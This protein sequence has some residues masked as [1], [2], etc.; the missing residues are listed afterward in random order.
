MDVEKDVTE[1]VR[2]IPS[3]SVRPKR[4]HMLSTTVIAKNIHCPSCIRH[5][6]DM[7][8]TCSFHDDVLCTSV[9]VVSGEIHVLHGA[10]VSLSDICQE[11]TNAAFEVD[12]AITVDVDDNVLAQLD[13]TAVSVDSDWE[14]ASAQ[15]K[16]PSLIRS[17]SGW[18]CGLSSPM[19]S[20]R[21]RHIE[22]CAACQENAA[23][24]KEVEDVASSRTLS[25]KTEKHHAD[26]SAESTPSTIRTMKPPHARSLSTDGSYPHATVDVERGDTRSGSQLYKWQISVGGMT[27]SSCSNTIKDSLQEL[28]YVKSVDVDLM[29]NSAVIVFNGGE[30][31]PDKLQAAIEELG[32]EVSGAELER[33]DSGLGA[34]STTPKRQGKSSA[35]IA[36]LSIGGMTC[37]SCTTAV[38]NALKDMPIVT[39]VNVSLMTNSA[40]VQLQAGKDLPDIVKA[41]EDLGYE[42]A[43]ESVTPT[44]EDDE[45]DDSEARARERSIQ[46][47]IDGMYCEHCPP[48]ILQALEGHQYLNVTKA[49][50][51]KDSLMRITYTPQ[52]PSFTVR[53]IVTTIKSLDPR[54]VPRIYH[55]PSLEE[56]SQQMQRHERKKILRRLVLSTILTI[57]TLLIGVIWMN[58]TSNA[59]SDFW[60]VNQKGVS[61]AEWALFA[62]ATPVYFCAAD[63]F[64]VRAIKEIRSLWRRGSKVPIHRRFIR[65]G[66]M[67]LLISAGTTVSYVS[68]LALLIVAAS[69]P[70]P[71]GSGAST[72]SY[73]DTVVFLTFFIL[74][75]RYLEAYSKSRAG[76]A[77]SML[78]QLRPREAIIQ[79]LPSAIS[80]GL[81]DK[82]VLD[83]DLVDIGDTIFV[84]HGS[85]PAADGV[86][87]SQSG[88]FDESSLTGESRLVN[89]T[90]G[91]KIFI[92]T[93]NAGT[94][95]AMKVTEVG[96]NSMLDQ[97]IAVVREGQTKRAPVERVAD[98]LTGYFVPV[99]T[100]LAI[101]T[102]VIWFALGQ[103]GALS[104]AYLHG[105]TGGWAFWSLQFAI[106][107]F[108]VACPCG[109]GLAAPTA[110]FVGSGLAAKHG[111]LAR[112]GGQAFQ[113]AGKLDAVVFDKT[114]T[115]TEG[116]NLKVTDH[117]LLSANAD[118]QAVIWCLARE[119]ESQSSHPMAQAISKAA[120][121]ASTTTTTQEALQEVPGAGMQGTFDFGSRGR[122]EAAIGS[123]AFI[124]SFGLMTRPDRSGEHAFGLLKRWQN[125]AKSTAILA[126]RYLD[127]PQ[128][129]NEWKL[130]ALFAVSDAIKP[131]ALPAIRALKK[132]GLHI[133]MLSGDNPTTARAVA[134]S[135]GISAENVFAGVPPTEKADKIK[136]LQD[137]LTPT[138]RRRDRARIAFVGDGINDAAALT[139]ADISISPCDASPI[140]L[141]ASSFVL[142]SPSLMTIPKLLDI[143]TRVFRR[144]KFNFMWALVYNVVLIPVA[145]GVLFKV[146][147]EGFR[148]SPVWG[149][150]AMAGSSVSVVISSLLLRW[151][152]WPWE[153]RQVL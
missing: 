54:F 65:F 64:H 10:S 25:P 66:S 29:N 74:I 141:T 108:V 22:H 128:D 123:Q 2:H 130:A 150:L 47:K 76:D 115:L 119:L 110:L 97:I 100:A 106:A 139:C 12:S 17:S 37:S 80:N 151:E 94:P 127:G 86:L 7:F 5:I 138:G 40:Q 145:A 20:K 14:G 21:K 38:T 31:T 105:Q 136:W 34:D 124:S 93:V 143:S 96:G 57:P 45:E 53:D 60:M 51:L 120:A 32:Y 153:K 144:V 113:N 126:M 79:T 149:S 70:D 87:T 132:R 109:V 72:T 102:F 84:P 125:E 39:T 46:L 142:M 49:P 28:D 137:N 62:L 129:D 103:S 148:L 71:T 75:G 63:L 116:G 18:P 133:Y 48:R 13:S 98:I 19:R 107:V 147:A 77:V 131:S 24:G 44:Q 121:I 81:A 58:L 117:E 88:K 42:C 11:V 67:N 73:F 16:R 85:S 82:E 112:G 3:E 41:V 68:S 101:I 61:R 8:A 118:E 99:I 95:V 36:K 35:V 146:Q 6:E 90:Q 55:P 78:S 26:L 152:R 92:G 114:G 122:Y 83:A 23:E 59:V 43:V 33:I 135:L 69:T 1:D 140:A 15:W 56:R 89:K 52:A 134:E 30:E 9:S 27:C 4:Q 104:P 50:T 91:D 111:I